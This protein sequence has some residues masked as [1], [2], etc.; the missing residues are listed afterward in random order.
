MSEDKLRIC[1]YCITGTHKLCRPEIKWYD[2]V[3]YCYCE[4]CRAQEKE[5]KTD[6]VVQEPIQEQEEARTGD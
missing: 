5:E 3:W 2:K 1:G 6:E 4:P